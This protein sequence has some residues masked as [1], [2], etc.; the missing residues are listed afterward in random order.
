MELRAGFKERLRTHDQK[1][2]FGCSY[3]GTTDDHD[4]AGCGKR[5]D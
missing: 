1:V 5:H 4:R 3:P 2:N